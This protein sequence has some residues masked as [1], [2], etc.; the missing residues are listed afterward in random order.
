[1]NKSTQKIQ[2]VDLEGQLL[3][4]MPG[5]PDERFA[6]SVVCLCAH[7]DE[8]AMG[9]IIN[10]PT[11]DLSLSELLQQVDL[12]DDEEAVGLAPNAVDH[13][14]HNGGPVE[15]SRGFVLHSPDYFSEDATIK[16]T[17][18]ICLTA[19]TDVLKAVASGK[20]PQRSM[21]ALGYAGWAP[22]QLESEL[23]AN[24]WLNCPADPDLVFARDAET[25]YSLAL[26]KLGV[27]PSHLVSIAGRA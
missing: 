10:K 24:G 7:S 25:K 16:I 21:L 19:T 14:I 8:G 3:I 9:L 5:M 20:G 12:D 23:G 22:G 1:M 2:D 17:D 27:N 6:R 26:T 4:A 11:H 15:S 18:G 13:P